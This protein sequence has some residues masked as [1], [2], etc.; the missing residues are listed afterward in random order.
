MI[1]EILYM[2][3]YGVY[4]W[5]SF[6]LTLVSFGILYSVVKVQLIKEKKKFEIKFNNLTSEKI[7]LAKKQKTY[8]EI[9]ANTSSYKI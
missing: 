5:S 6:I 9:L 3:G 2:D 8:R 1:N 4:V 7:D